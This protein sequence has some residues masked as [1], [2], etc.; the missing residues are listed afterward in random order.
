MKA[1]SFPSSP[2]SKVS[3]LLISC[4]QEPA[5]KFASSFSSS[6][7]FFSVPLLFAPGMSLVVCLFFLPRPPVACVD[8]GGVADGESSAS[9]R[10]F[11]EDI[12]VGFSFASFSF[13]LNCGLPPIDWK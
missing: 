6:L 4:S 10:F 12:G 11:D 13:V 1:Q 8:A 5:G 2:L 3:M 9:L 7:S